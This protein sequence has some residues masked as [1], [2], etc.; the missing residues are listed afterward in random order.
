MEERHWRWLRK[1]LQGAVD[2]LDLITRRENGR[3]KLVTAAVNGERTKWG[4]SLPWTRDL[5]SEGSVQ[6]VKVGL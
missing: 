6:M 3:C 2:L 5:A 1:L 4:G